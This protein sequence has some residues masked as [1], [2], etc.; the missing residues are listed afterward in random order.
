[1]GIIETLPYS[2]VGNYF[3]RLTLFSFDQFDFVVL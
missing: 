2:E 3:I 1:M